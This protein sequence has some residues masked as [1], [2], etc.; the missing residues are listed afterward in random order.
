MN[1]TPATLYVLLNLDDGTVIG[2]KQINDWIKH[3]VVHVNLSKLNSPESFLAFLYAYNH[4]MVS[5]TD[6]D[7]ETLIVHP[8]SSVRES[9]TELLARTGKLTFPS[10]LELLERPIF[11]VAIVIIKQHVK[12][13]LVST[14]MLN[15]LTDSQLSNLLPFCHS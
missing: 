3:V 8:D 1:L 5:D 9:V 10:L 12:D 7:V 13:L 2:Q 4:G 14:E 15:E 6:F 11:G